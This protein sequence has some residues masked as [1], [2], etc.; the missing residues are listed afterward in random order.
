MSEN[1]SISSDLSINDNN[2][3]SNGL[4][5]SENDKLN[6]STNSLID[7]NNSEILSNKSDFNTGIKDNVIPSNQSI[8]GIENKDKLN[9]SIIDNTNN[10]IDISSKDNNRNKSNIVGNR[11]HDI[12][13]PSIYGLQQQKI[14]KD[15][16][17]KSNIKPSN[18]INNT[19]IGN[20]NLK[21]NI[22][23][24]N[25]STIDRISYNNSSS[26]IKNINIGQTN[27]NVSKDSKINNSKT[28]VFRKSN[29]N[30]LNN[31]K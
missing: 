14:N 15:D 6:S 12:L 10:P 17:N 4:S 5:I 29:I 21:P 18:D 2:S 25:I 3:I 20:T 7:M 24:N 13:N 9:K 19:K 11:N 31:D 26:D 23:E 28:N 16:L 30:P 27:K 1:D 8:H 22:N